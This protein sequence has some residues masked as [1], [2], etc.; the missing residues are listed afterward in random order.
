MGG[1]R[2][3]GVI[4]IGKTNAKVAVADLATE[5]EIGVL[6]RPNKVLAGPPWPHFDLDGHW[7]FIL[8]ALRD[9]H[10]AHGI[11]AI[12]VTTHGA[13]AVL[14]DKDGNLA[15]PMLDY[16][17]QGPDSLAAQY[18]AIRPDFAETG[19][20]RLAMGLNLGAQ[21]FWQLRT[22]PELLER[23]ATVLTYPQYWGFRL[24]GVRAN[25][26]TSLGCH[27]DL[28]APFEGRYSSLVERLG[29]GGKMAPV[30]KAADRL[31]EILPEIAKRTGLPEGLPVACGIHDSNASLY[32][33][34]LKRAAPFSVVSTG[35]WVIVLAIGG[36]TPDLD[37]ARDTLIN[38]NAFG[39]PVPSARFMGGREFERI[40]ADHGRTWTDA[41]VAKVLE[42]DIMLLPAVEPRS[43]PFQGRT[44]RWSVAESGL[45]GGERFVALSYYLAL[46][47][48]ECLMMTGAAGPIVVEGPFSRNPLYRQMLEAATGRPV[49]A[50][51]A[52][53]TGTGIGAALLADCDM[54]G[55][56]A[57]AGET[58]ASASADSGLV[59]YAARWREAVR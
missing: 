11:E 2:H 3:V 32:P 42:K 50:S 48:A 24:T 31:G 21:L 46:M 18:D 57:S 13:S 40:C 16:E 20:P 1:I 36:R 44:H 47:T 19:S 6:T 58:G 29:L 54:S 7:S 43:G 4:D 12:S 15:A 34:L 53:V 8:D 10:A 51:Q 28:W 41:D 56:T 14:L 52:S 5:R 37:P 22:D 27:T 25:E 23:T 45:A 9:L 38:V 35:T 39:D 33:H 55:E 30:R 26:V 17:F 59:A 49:A